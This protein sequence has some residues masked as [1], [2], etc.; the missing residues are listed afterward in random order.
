MALQPASKAEEAIH[1]IY[2]RWRS[3]ILYAGVK[4][5]VLDQ[6]TTEIFQT[7]DALAMTLNVSA[8]LLY[9][10]MRALASI[11]VLIENN[12]HAFASTEVGKLFR[13][14]H[15]H[16]LRYL[17]LTAEGPEHYAIWKHLPDIM[18]DGGHDGFI[19]EFGASAFEYG[20]SND[21]YRR[22]FDQ[23]MTGH[24]A[25]Q[26]KLVLDALTDRDFSSIGTVCDIGGGHGHLLCALLASRPH[27]KGIV[28][29]LPE[30]FRRADDLQTIHLE[31][32]DR[33]SYVSGDMFEEVPRADAYILKMILHNWSDQECVQVLQNL[34][35]KTPPRGR[36]FVIEHVVP[37]PAESHFAKLFDI[38]MLC[39]GS[40]RERTES[41]YAELLQAAGWTLNRTW[42]P[43]NRVI[44]VV[45][46][47]P[48]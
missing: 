31:L 41:E 42:Y 30:A 38:H 18:R 29:D 5:G 3:Q 8:K 43:E 12:S 27:L 45:E 19:R 1:L 37:G 16:T 25:F 14:D 7:A 4:L 13:S 15:P 9:R 40:G 21:I 10:L 36:V 48:L 33:C 39:W 32:Q 22:T 46:G 20:R 35:K 34:R 24:S 17:V 2:G 23:A 11:G 44:G 28:F 26:S 6:S 47:S